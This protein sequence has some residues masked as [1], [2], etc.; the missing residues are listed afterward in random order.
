M[1]KTGNEIIA[2]FMGYVKKKE[3]YLYLLPPPKENYVMDCRDFEFSTSWSWLMPVVEKI[4]SLK[5]PVY[6]YVSHIQK[7]CVIHELNKEDGDGVLVR[8]SDT[9]PSAIEITYE[10]VVEFIRG[11]NS[12]LS[13]KV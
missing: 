6:I 2:E 1:E 12:S 4:A 5:H 11:Y 7:S 13:P 10:S 9:R 3:S 8:N